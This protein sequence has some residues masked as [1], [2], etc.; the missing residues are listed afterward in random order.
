[1]TLCIHAMTQCD[2]GVSSR[3]RQTRLKGINSTPSITSEWLIEDEETD[4]KTI[5]NFHLFILLFFDSVTHSS[6][7][8]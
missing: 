3:I 6:N 4:R 1:M 5:P 8:Y 2:L 7:F